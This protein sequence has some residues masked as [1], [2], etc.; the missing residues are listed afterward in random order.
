MN[1]NN[2]NTSS[3]PTRPTLKGTDALTLRNVGRV[4][5]TMDMGCKVTETLSSGLFLAKDHAQHERKGCEWSGRDPRF[6]LRPRLHKYRFRA[7]HLLA[8]IRNRDKKV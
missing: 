6:G 1:H 7:Q 4:F 8:L 3:S 5:K 2:K